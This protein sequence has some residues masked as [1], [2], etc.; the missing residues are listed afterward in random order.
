MENSTPTHGLGPVAARIDINSARLSSLAAKSKGL[1][2]YIA[3]HPKGGADH[4]NAK[5][6]FKLG[7]IVI[8]QIECENVRDYC[9]DT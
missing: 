2:R 7:D 5:A 1:N 4:P 3:N 9:F 8:T 6:T